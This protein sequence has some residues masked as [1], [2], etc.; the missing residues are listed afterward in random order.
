MDFNVTICSVPQNFDDKDFLASS[1]KMGWWSGRDFSNGDFLFVG[2]LEKRWVF[3][4]IPD[5][6]GEFNVQSFQSHAPKR[7]QH[8]QENKYDSQIGSSPQVGAKIKKHLKPPPRKSPTLLNSERFPNLSGCL[9]TGTASS[10]VEPGCPMY[11]YFG[12]I[13]WCPPKRH[14][15]M[16]NVIFTYIWP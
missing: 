3:K 16:L 2:W 11:K 1:Q 12:R 5:K 4:Q 6:N 8:H 15:H 13:F 10:A 7:L 9:K 14:T